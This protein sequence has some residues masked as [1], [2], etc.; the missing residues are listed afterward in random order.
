M[1]ARA[2]TPYAAGSGTECVYAAGVSN[3]TC[4]DRREFER[5]EASLENALKRFA[6]A[7]LFLYFGT[8]SAS[9]RGPLSPYVAHKV[10]MERLAA[11]HARALVIRLPQLAG[12]SENTHT[13]LNYLFHRV[14]R[15]ERFQVWM[16]AR[17]NII[18]VDDAARIVMAAARDGMRGAR[19][20]VASPFDSAATEIV[21]TMTM[22]VGKPAI[23]DYVDAGDSLEIDS[24]RS[25]ELAARC[26]VTFDEG[27]LERVIRKYYGAGVRREVSGPSTGVVQPL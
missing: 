18:D 27:Y 19:L 12:R 20:D 4:A 6:S 2:F 14:S 24:R 26:G 22:V 16:R 17:R 9:M 23:C 15:G 5:E 13:L 21:Q 1:L 11:T 3:S 7:D 8:C 25:S 10:A